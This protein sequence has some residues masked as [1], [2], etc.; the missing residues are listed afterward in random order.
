M[1]DLAAHAIVLSQAVQQTDLSG[2]NLVV[3]DLVDELFTWTQAT[4]FN[5]WSYIWF[6]D[7]CISEL[8]RHFQPPRSLLEIQ[9]VWYG[10]DPNICKS[11]YP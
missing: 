5:L 7:V 8:S 6:L 4:R 10:M 11:S 2:Q 1:V 3:G 9:Y